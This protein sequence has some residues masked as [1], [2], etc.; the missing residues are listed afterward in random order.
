MN[1]AD[2]AMY[3]S[4]DTMLHPKSICIFGATESKPITYGGRFIQCLTGM[5]YSG[6]IYPINPRYKTVFGIPCY[7]DLKSLPEAPDLAGVVVPYE[8]IR[9]VITDCGDV[10]VKSAVIITGQFA[11]LGTGERVETQKWLGDFA[12]TKNVRL[13]GPNCLGIANVTDNIWPCSSVMEQISKTLPGSLAMVSQSGACAFGPFL[14]RAQARRIG[15]SYIVSTG[16]E[17]DF[18]APDFIRYCLQ[19]DNVKGVIAYFEGI[20]DGEKFRAVAEEALS[21]GK[22][23]VALKVGRSGAGQTAARSHTASMT[24]SDEVVDAMFKQMGITR[25]ED[26]DE[27]VEV[28]ACMVKAKPMTKKTVAI[29][30]SSGGVTTQIADK[31]DRVV[32]IPPASPET[33]AGLNKILG[34]FGSAGNPAGNPAD[35]TGRAGTPDFETIL[36]LMLKDEAFGG[37]ALGLSGGEEHAKRILNA[38][39]KTDK[40]IFQTWIASETATEGLPTLQTSSNIS[41]FFR[42]DNMVKGIGA[43]VSYHERREKYTSGELMSPVSTYVPVDDIVNKSGNLELRKGME[44]LSLFGIPTAKTASAGSAGEAE[45]IA[46]GFG[47]PVVL[48]AE[49]PHKTDK[50]LVRINLA[51]NSA[52]GK[53]YRDISTALKALPETANYGILVQQMVRGGVEV[54]VGVKNDPVFGP[55]VLFGMGG[56]LTELMKDVS[57]RVCPLSLVDVREMMAEVKG[58]KLLQGFRGQGAYDIAALEDTLLKVSSMAYQLKDRLSELD[59]NPLIVLPEG[60]GVRAVDVLTV[61]G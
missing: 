9:Q 25:I 41:E 50:G 10:G 7:P 35:V 1:K 27:L 48:K 45:K 57:L 49:M 5:K 31:C 21:M 6:R 55:T 53:A 36:D 37:L 22:P 33:C 8:A 32:G 3:Q 15:L 28:G 20:K 59:I 12:K 18:Q 58:F 47:F 4:I 17:A 51:S 61:L 34:G 39:A 52:V 19:Q 44:L 42:I 14:Q 43:V 56:I 60:K 46:G 30:S 11:E 24:G 54:I 26:W 13:C 38:A 23:I 2:E 29:I 40:P 16:N